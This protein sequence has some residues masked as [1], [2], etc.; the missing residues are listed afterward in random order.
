M[1]VLALR[2]R[3]PGEAAA[4]TAAIF[5]FFAALAAHAV[6]LTAHVHSGDPAS[7]GWASAGGWP[8]ILGLVQRCTV[9]ALLPLPLVAI[10]VPLALTGW[11][12]LRGET[13][14]RAAFLLILYITAF[15][16]IGRSDN[17][18][19]GLMIAPLLPLGLAFA[20]AALRDLARAAAGPLRR[21][22]SAT[23]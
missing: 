14:D 5:I 23:A 20:P 9:F 1:A 11:A 21:D 17:F 2:E 15:M 13:G 7:P 12:G 10:A 18:Y 22:I 6:A 8:F 3:N 19:W 16:L 4:W